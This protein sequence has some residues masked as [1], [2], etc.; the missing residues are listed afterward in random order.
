MKNILQV[1]LAALL[2]SSLCL[3]APAQATQAVVPS[4]IAPCDGGTFTYVDYTG[5]DS[6]WGIWNFTA[7]NT[8][9]GGYFGWGTFIDSTVEIGDCPDPCGYSQVMDSSFT[10]G[11]QWI[12]N[13][14]G[15]TVPNFTS[16]TPTL[17]GTTFAIVN[18]GSS[19][20]M[21]DVFSKTWKTLPSAV[22]VT[23]VSGF[24]KDT[25]IGVYNGTVYK[26]NWTTQQ[27]ESYISA[28][29]YSN[30]VSPPSSGYLFGTQTSTGKVYYYLDYN[31][32]WN[33]YGVAL[34]GL[35]K[36]TVGWRNA[37]GSVAYWGGFFPTAISGSHAYALNQAR[38]AW[39]QIDSGFTP[40]DIQSSSNVTVA[41]DISGNLWRL[42]SWSG[43]VGGTWTNLGAIPA[44]LGS[45]AVG[46]PADVYAYG[47]S[48]VQRFVANG[49]LHFATSLY[50]PSLRA[51]TGSALGF[52]STLLPNGENFL[53]SSHVNVNSTCSGTLVDSFWSMFFANAVI[54]VRWPKTSP[55]YNC[56]WN[57]NFNKFVCQFPV[58]VWCTADTQPN[59]SGVVNKVS[60][61]DSN[62]SPALDA[63]YWWSDRWC[64]RVPH[65]TGWECYSAGSIANAVNPL[66]GNKT[67]TTN[68]DTFEYFEPELGVCTNP[69][70]TSD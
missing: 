53:A 38:T 5:Y 62:G 12:S 1:L 9:S 19:L 41:R 14:G 43:Q 35:T 39:V 23:S 47:N 8:R 50:S 36:F 48:S 32:T 37:G 6:N 42:E 70:N 56:A 10:G 13:I 59:Y 4:S 7:D 67:G 22:P 40:V 16:I 66:A 27:W 55:K 45:Y 52:P 63:R 34:P 65:M 29:G 69:P 18:N 46:G 25:L 17:D 60:D 3:P 2:L 20:Y 26:Y 49:S 61:F 30:I 33:S 64:L 24:S 11:N 51:S 58:N 44:G 31:H 28:A 54:K 15:A 21:F 68:Q 57:S